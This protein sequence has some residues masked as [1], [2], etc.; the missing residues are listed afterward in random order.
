[1]LEARG[2][3]EALSGD[4]MDWCGTPRTQAKKPVLIVLH[5]RHSNPGHVGQWF[6]RN[7]YALDIRRH[8][9]DDPLPETLEH[10]C[11]A[12]IFGGP[13][14]A[15]DCDGFVKREIE[16][17]GVAL[18][19]KKPFLGICLGAQ[20]LARYLGARVDHCRHGCVEIGYH[21]IRAHE[22]AGALG[23]LPSYV[24]EWHREG[25]Q[26]PHGG[27]LLA[28][29][30]GP[31]PNQ[32]MSFGP[33]AVGIQFHPEITFAQVNRW[34]GSNPIRLLMKGARPRHDH[35]SE[36]LIYGPVVRNWLDQFLRRWVACE[37]PL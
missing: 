22:D 14:S 20:M 25:F 11:G 37:L 10:H 24:Y 33:T 5:Q 29:A 19:E 12:V 30:D 23:A 15:N 8:C 4:L 35:L 34:S 7:G 28:V 1:M 16:W 27:R 21:P 26:I 17:I 31:F 9:F 32:A 18:R 3:R 6:L 13:Q 36:H 2:T